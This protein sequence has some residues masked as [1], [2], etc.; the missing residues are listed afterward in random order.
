[1]CELVVVIGAIGSG[2]SFATKNRLTK[3]I[4]KNSLIFDYNQ[5]YEDLLVIHPEE[6]ISFLNGTK[7]RVGR[8]IP[9][10]NDQRMNGEQ[11][12]EMLCHILDNVTNGILVLESVRAYTISQDV[13]NKIEEKILS[14]KNNATIISMFHS[15]A[16]TPKDFINKADLV[17]IHR[18]IESLPIYSAKIENNEILVIATLIVANKQKEDKYFF[19]EVHNQ[20][21]IIGNFSKDDYRNA[22]LDYMIMDNGLHRYSEHY[23]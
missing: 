17:V 6:A 4:G 12:Q 16:S 15:F 22:C 18:Q 23:Y 3:V 5:E 7:G 1:M 2:K 14:N 8:I 11:I 10:V 13:Q 20:K 19:C 9:L 21:Q